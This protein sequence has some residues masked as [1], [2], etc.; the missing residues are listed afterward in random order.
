MMDPWN[1]HASASVA[2][3]M[4]HFRSLREATADQYVVVFVGVAW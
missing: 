2:S 4:E 3:V 1:E